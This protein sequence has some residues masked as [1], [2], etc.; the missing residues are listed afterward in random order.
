MQAKSSKMFVVIFIAVIVVPL[1]ILAAVFAANYIRGN[2]MALSD[3]LP[4]ETSRVKSAARKQSFDLFAGYSSCENAIREKA[5]GKVI[6]LTSD[7][8]AAK[9]NTYTNTNILTFKA[10][11]VPPN[12][13]FLSEQHSTRE[14]DIKCATS[15]SSN[16]VVNLNMSLADWVLVSIVSL[17]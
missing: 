12:E 8:R 5:E 17:S 6:S 10:N 4:F 2:S 14:Y 3:M 13:R 11:I 15:I 9:V 1:S 7:D 16:A